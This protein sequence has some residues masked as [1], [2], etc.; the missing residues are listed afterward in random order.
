MGSLTPAASAAAA[1]DQPQPTP[2]WPAAAS[3]AGTSSRSVGHDLRR[4][5]E[6]LRETR[7]MVARRERRSSAAGGRQV[8]AGPRLLEA[9]YSS[10][11]WRSG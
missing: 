3:S 9:K 10:S 11:R 4:R 2:A 1:D 6:V 8:P 7:A 5:P